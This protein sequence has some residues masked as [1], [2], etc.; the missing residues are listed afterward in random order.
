MDVAP[1]KN[2]TGTTQ[3]SVEGGHYT[4]IHLHQLIPAS[5]IGEASTFA[6]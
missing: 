4:P 2:E 5:Q 1:T 6:W 3:A